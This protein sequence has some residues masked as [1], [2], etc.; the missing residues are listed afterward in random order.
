MQPNGAM[1]VL[2]GYFM[3]YILLEPVAAVSFLVLYA[4]YST[5][6]ALC[7][8]HQLIHPDHIRPHPHSH[9]PIRHLPSQLHSPLTT[10]SQYLGIRSTVFHPICYCSARRRVDCPVYRTWRV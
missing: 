5:L 4:L 10:L 9:V 1:A 2:S 3:Y 7:S 8:T 6:Y